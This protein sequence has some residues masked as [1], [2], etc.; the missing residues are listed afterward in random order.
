MAS[1]FSKAMAVLGQKRALTARLATPS[2]GLS[3]PTPKGGGFS[4]HTQ[5]GEI[6]QILN[7]ITAA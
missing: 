2:V 7:E 5:L 6:E 3:L 4:A 1:S